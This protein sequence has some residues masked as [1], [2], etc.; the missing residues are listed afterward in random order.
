VAGEGFFFQ[1]FIYLSAA[2]ISVPIAKRLGLGSV[3]GY[4]LAGIIIGPFVLKLVGREG[5]DLMH[6]AEF[7]VVMMLFLIGLELQPRLL[8][9][10]R[11][12]LLGMGGLQVGVTAGLFMAGGLLLGLA[13]QAALAVGLILSLSSTAIV[14]QSFAE[15]GLMQSEP[16]QSSFAVLLFQ[17]LAVIPMLAVLP[18][19]ATGPAAAEAAGGQAEAASW[20]VGWPVW[21]R[22]AVDLGVMS[23]IVIAGRYLVTPVFRFIARTKLREMFTAAALLLVIGIAMLMS[24]V[25]L[26][27][28]LGTFLAGVVLASS[29]Y[30]HELEGDIEPFKGLLLGLFFIA[31][32]ASID[33]GLIVRQTLRI[34]ALVVGLVSLKFL[35]VL[36]LSGLFKMRTPDRLLVAYSL[37]Q[38]G[39]FAFVLFSMAVQS[40]VFGAG[41]ADSLV[42]AVAISMALS[43]LL[44]VLGSRTAR[45][46]PQKAQRAADEV[47]EKNPVIVVGFGRFGNIV[48]RLLRANGVGATVLD[49]DA[50]NV[51][52]LR[53]LGLKVFYG[54]AS[55][56][57]LLRAAG[58][59]WA[60]LII[61]AIDDSEKTLELVR[62]VRRSF[63]HL[64]ILARANGRTDAYELL[65]AGVEHVYRETL[66]S[67]LRVGIDA[68]RLLGFRSHQAHRSARTFRKTD[69]HDLRALASLRHDHKVYLNSARQRI[70][71]LERALRSEMEGHVEERDAGWDTSGLRAEVRETRTT[72]KQP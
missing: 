37:A 23:A 20:V 58:A 8:W 18:L 12:S 49:V 17:D 54:D 71:D 1:A 48:G 50:G 67:S 3:L 69:E 61:L 46:K 34:A 6:F 41:I 24:K 2:V 44:M 11:L 4:L 40:R 21:A 52:M 53:R 68:L 9:R 22:A 42:A 25:G 15:R 7:G 57:D 56:P 55:R 30:R 72:A 60:R 27:P 35:T 66:D 38:G 5:Q 28:A 39:E 47:N 64:Q 29:E 16:G 33:F 63:P 51:E 10:M 59:E 62:T 32:G 26:S 45:V 70:E 19:L 36:G 43:P 31:V 14:L 65:E 13:W